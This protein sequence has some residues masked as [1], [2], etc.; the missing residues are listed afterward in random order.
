M[1]S[2]KEVQHIAALARIGL[3]EKEIEKYAKDLSSILGWIEQ[4]KEAGI[5]GVEPAAHITGMENVVREDETR[6]FPDKNAIV[7]L[8]PEEKNGFDKV[9]SILN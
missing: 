7:K 4:L 8:F 1:I 2:K 6:E 9:R 5:E 3:D